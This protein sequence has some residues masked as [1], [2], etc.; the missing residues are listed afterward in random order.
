MTLPMQNALPRALLVAFAIILGLLPATAVQ[1]Q[2]AEGMRLSGYGTLG[3]VQD[4]RNDIVAIR[5]VSQRPDSDMSRGSWQ[6]D[7]RIG[8][9]GEYRVSPKFDLVGQAVFRDQFKGDA[10]HAVELAYVGMKPTPL[11]DVRVGRVGYDAFLMSDIRNVGYAYPW[12]RPFTEY[13][14]WI[15][16]FSVDGAD[17]S[18]VIPQGDAQW[19]L[20]VQAGQSGTVIPIGDSKLDFK[21]DDLVA[22]TLS[23]RADEWE[24]KLG[25]ST[26]TSRNEVTAAGAG[27]GL[28]ALQEG[29]GAVAAATAAL[30]P[31]ISHEAADLRQQLSF[32][33]AR[34]NYLTLG[35][36]YDNRQWLL[37]GELART[38]SSHKIVPHGTMGY[39]VL[40]YHAGDW[41]PFVAV[42]ASRP[43]NALRSA[44]ADWS[45]IGQAATQ[46]TAIA[47]LN[48]TRMNQTTL[49]LGTR[50]DFQ[51]R[52]A[53][54]L[55][56]DFTRIAP[57]GYGLLFKDPALETR[58]SHMR[59]I[60]LTLDFLF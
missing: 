2:L 24:M 52:A 41:T 23:H 30:A 21:T 25:Y 60:S 43:G 38:T 40:G 56:G 15:P 7:S 32:K 45:V 49:S 33:N 59:Q 28:A 51:K 3:Y 17:I 6:R 31:A 26:F 14:G 54:K 18:Y 16:L 35:A 22:L 44:S 27:G 4:N 47:V 57:H 20:K 50:W 11:M 8:I 1:A 58:S 10:A 42:S 5:D 48:S 39:A 29:M 9:Q 55:Q 19:R 37:Q 53:L 36:S 12:V 46:A 34:I 13:Y